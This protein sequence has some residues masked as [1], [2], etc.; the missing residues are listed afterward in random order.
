MTTPEPTVAHFMTSDPATADE[1]LRLSDAQERMYL[2]NIRHLVAH[3]GGRVTGVI[4]TRDVTVALGVKGADPTEL[5]VR[6]AMSTHPYLCPPD[7]PISVVAHE[8]ETHRYGCAIVV[9]GDELLGMFTTTDALRA[10]R[11]LATGRPAEP[12][13][14]PTLVAEPPEGPQY[15]IRLRRHRPIDQ[16]GMWPNEM[17]IR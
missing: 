15:H 9:E 6:D 14:K 8:M 1:G 2:N 11:E 12:A 17:R 10:V 13:V 5:T 4:S 7:T 16:H 3:R